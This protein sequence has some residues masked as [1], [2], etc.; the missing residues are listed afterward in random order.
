MESKKRKLSRRMSSD[1][2]S[3]FILTRATPED[4]SRA[5]SLDQA[6][7]PSITQNRKKVERRLSAHKIN[8]HLKTRPSQE[9]L[10]EQGIFM[11][12]PGHSSVTQN[13][14]RKL[15][16]KLTANTIKNFHKRTL[17]RRQESIDEETE[18]R[19]DGTRG[20]A[21]GPEAQGP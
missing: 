20:R 18:V 21:N 4:A 13:A 7:S 3:S 12:Q 16:R 2:I 17:G 14:A 19:W 15:E 5:A 11:Y 1:T 6:I 9:T 10:H 8:D